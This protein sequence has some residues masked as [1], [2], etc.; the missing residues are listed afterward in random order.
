[1]TIRLH[2]SSDARAPIL[3]GT[4]GELNALL[5]A[6]LVNGF[7][8]NPALG[9]TRPYYDAVTN[10]TVFLQGGT[11]PRYLQID[12]NA[13]GAAGAG[14]ARAAGYESM[15]AFNIGVDRFPIVF[16]TANAYPIRKSNSLD[17]S[18]RNWLLIGDERRFLLAIEC[19]D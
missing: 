15:T 16:A 4:T 17:T 8:S 6:C 18:P 2:K 7:G 13:S 3:S 14:E 19:G 1:M 9:W 5:L 10:I 12:D 11:T